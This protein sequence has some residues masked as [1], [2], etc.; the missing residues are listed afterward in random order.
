MRPRVTIIVPTYNRATLVTR[1]IDSALGQ[2]YPN[3]EVLVVDNGSTDD[4]PQVLHLYDDEPRLR[5]V[6]HERN[7]GVTA[8]KNTGLSNLAAET[9]YVGILDDDDTLVP[10]AIETLVQVFEANEGCYSQVF[11]WCVDSVSGELSG[12]MPHREGPITYDDALSGRFTGEFFQLASRALLE[13]RRFDERAAGAESAVWW[14]LLRERDG[15]VVKEVVHRYDTSGNDRVSTVG[16]TRSTATGRMWACYAGLAAVGDDLRQR[17]PRRYGEGLIELAKWA[18]LAGE[19][20][21]ARAA[22]REGVRY[23]RSRRSLVMA[24]LILLPASF[25]RSVAGWR[26]KLRDAA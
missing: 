24:A 8:A 5:V 13:G 22:A 6:R 7:Q 3:L 18:A 2:T 11:G 10:S 4:T 12:R 16:Y 19:P 15:W 9:V 26:S 23:A 1:A 14:P 17:Y 20:R 25:L 21:R